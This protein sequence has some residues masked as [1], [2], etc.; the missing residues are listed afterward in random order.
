MT[1]VYKLNYRIID[2]MAPF[3]DAEKAHQITFK[4]IS[5]SISPSGRANGMYRGKPREFCLPGDHARENLLPVIREEVL[6]FSRGAGSSGTR[7]SIMGPRTIS[8]ARRSAA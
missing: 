5:P 7:R 6:A 8:A 3:A 1:E 4:A 2:S